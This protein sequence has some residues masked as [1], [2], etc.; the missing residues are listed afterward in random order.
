VSDVD[1]IFVAEAADAVT[2]RVAGEMMR[3]A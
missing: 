1:V 2:T 3:F